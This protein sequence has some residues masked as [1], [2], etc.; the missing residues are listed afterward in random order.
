[1]DSDNVRFSDCP[2]YTRLATVWS[3][4]GR[5]APQILPL[6]GPSCC[7]HAMRLTVSASMKDGRPVGNRSSDFESF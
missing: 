3:F 1:M 6:H 7:G 4:R 2:K 5:E